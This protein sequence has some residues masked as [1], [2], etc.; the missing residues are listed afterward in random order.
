MSKISQKSGFKRGF[1]FIFLSVR[2]I[3]NSVAKIYYNTTEAF[4]NFSLFA[5]SIADKFVMFL[6]GF[7][8]AGI[9]VK[10]RD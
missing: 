5:F 2:P 6:Q 7:L 4:K 8:C 9:S 1:A 3:E 10:L